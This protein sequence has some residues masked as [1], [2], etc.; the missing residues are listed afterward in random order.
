MS[1]AFTRYRLTP[2]LGK[3]RDY[4]CRT[5]Y[6]FELD[7]GGQSGT[8]LRIGSREA[9]PD[10]ANLATRAFDRDGQLI[11][12]DGA[13]RFALEWSTTVDATIPLELTVWHIPS[14]AHRDGAGLIAPP[15]IMHVLAMGKDL[16]VLASSS[17]RIATGNVLPTGT[18]QVGSRIPLVNGYEFY[19]YVSS[20]SPNTNWSVQ[21]FSDIA[22]AGGMIESHEVL[23]AAFLDN[24]RSFVAL[25]PHPS[26]DGWPLQAPPEAFEIWVFNNTGA[27]DIAVSY[28]V[29]LIK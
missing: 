24:A 27:I 20:D 2:E 8:R 13:T 10:F 15:R 22:A 12:A 29:A 7:S 14:A 9:Q 23:A 25:G 5:A 3:T 6:A 1:D 16:P 17:E 19:G 28:F 11:P 21:V 4:G 18:V 26:T